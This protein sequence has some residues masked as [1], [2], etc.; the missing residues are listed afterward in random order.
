MHIYFLDT[1][2][3]MLDTIHA[4]RP[5][6]H[7]QGCTISINLS[8]S[9][10]LQALSQN[11]PALIF[12]DTRYHASG[13]SL[14]HALRQANP[15]CHLV[16]L[17]A[18]PEDMSFCLQNL[19]RPSGFLLKPTRGSELQSLIVAVL[20]LTSV[21]KTDTICISSQIFKRTLP[22]NQI[23]YFSTQGKKLICRTIEGETI[24]FYG[25]L[26]SLSQKYDGDFIRCHSGFL[27]NRNLIAGIYKG[28]LQLK[29]CRE[30]L[31]IS[32]K[33]KSSVLAFLKNKR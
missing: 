27:A 5:W 4:L 26:K 22:T 6:L 31:P 13:F 3:E 20:K 21:R 28:M 17:S 15:F 10:L 14:A 2:A 30:S 1:D 12:L 8:P 7:K 23:L 32:K 18:F 19:L 33:Y 24:P 29:N 9:E 16:F 25:T 11:V